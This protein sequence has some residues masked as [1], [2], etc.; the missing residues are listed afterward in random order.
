M[1]SPKNYIFHH[2]LGSECLFFIFCLQ[3]R[4]WCDLDVFLVA[5]VEWFSDV[6]SHFPTLSCTF[7][8]VSFRND[9]DFFRDKWAYFSR[10]CRALGNILH[11]MLLSVRSGCTF[12]VKFE[13]DSCSFF[14]LY[15]PLLKLW[16][17]FSF[18]LL[19]QPSLRLRSRRSGIAAERETLRDLVAFAYFLNFH[20]FTSV[21]DIRSFTDSAVYV[22]CVFYT[23]SSA[24]SRRTFFHL[25][26]FILVIKVVLDHRL[27]LEWSGHL[28]S[29]R[30]EDWYCPTEHCSSVSKVPSVSSQQRAGVVF[31]LFVQTRG[32]L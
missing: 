9:C 2:H 8:R 16:S 14:R 26:V 17:R 31:V 24:N 32:F 7:G 30:D 18:G 10:H 11:F 25:F 15:T 13:L 20:T 1:C 12:S 23:R 21:G 28:L 27:H 29:V 4:P 19:K 6:L 5:C 3:N 22:V